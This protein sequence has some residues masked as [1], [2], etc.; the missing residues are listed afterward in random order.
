MLNKLQFE[1][2]EAWVKEDARPLESAKWDFIFNNGD[3]EK[4]VTE[5]LKYQNED[6]GF[7]HG[8]ELDCQNPNS[9]P[10]QFFWGAAG[11]LKEIGCDTPDN[12][13]SIRH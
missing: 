11:I 12:R 3:C 6:G 8:I 7:G 5:I 1:K 13:G 4:I 10:V 9:Q 2:I